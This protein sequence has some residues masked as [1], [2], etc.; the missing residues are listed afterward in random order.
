MERSNDGRNSSGAPP[1]SPFAIGLAPLGERPWLVV[2]E[3]LA[4]YRNEKAQLVARHGDRVFMA[5]GATVDGQAETCRRIEAWLAANHPAAL[6]LPVPDLGPAPLQRAAAMCAEDL[7]LMRRESDGWHLAAA[8]LCFPS[9]WRLAGKFG[10]VM[11]AVHAPV[12]GFAGGTRNAMLVN[13]I[14]D[15]LAPGAAV[16]RGNWSIY[17]DDILHHPDPH[18]GERGADPATAAIEDLYLRE[19]RQTLTRL[20][21]TGDILFTILV[22]VSPLPD[23]GETAAGRARAGAL[24]AQIGAMSIEELAYKGMAMRRDLLCRLLNGIA[25]G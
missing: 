19:E 13:R 2:D 21:E 11:E 4:A 3:R 7:V 5:D 14:F 17:G 24:A 12:P 23:L 16:L 20:P 25:G 22:S 1:A 18:A 15:N 10:K 9:S 8:S 6:K